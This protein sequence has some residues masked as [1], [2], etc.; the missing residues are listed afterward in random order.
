MFDCIFCGIAAHEKPA[1]ILY[2]D[3]LCVVFRDINPQAP[4]HLQ[5]IPRKHITSLNDDLEDEKELLGHML[6]VVGRTAKAQGI[7][8]PGFRTVINTNAEGGQR[9]YHLHIHI[10]GGRKLGW[11]PG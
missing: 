5:V 2:E 7:D 9:I 10:L 11:P 4:I 6:A 8:G 1:K 3:E